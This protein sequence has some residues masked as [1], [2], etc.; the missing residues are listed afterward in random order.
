[1]HFCALFSVF[2]WRL[3]LEAFV[4]EQLALRSTV[5]QENVC[6]FDDFASAHVSRAGSEQVRPLK[7][8]AGWL[9]LDEMPLKFIASGHI[10]SGSALTRA[11]ELS[12]L[13]AGNGK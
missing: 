11:D 5:S 10:N 8:F 3:A 9:F 7:I 4:E 2:L 13:C 6:A 12:P 1:M